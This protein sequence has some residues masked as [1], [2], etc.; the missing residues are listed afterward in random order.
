MTSFVGGIIPITSE[1]RGQ[2]SLANFKAFS[3]VDIF[4]GR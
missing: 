1:L 2:K 3:Q 4:A